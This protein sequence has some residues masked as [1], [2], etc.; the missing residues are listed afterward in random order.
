MTSKIL[1]FLIILSTFVVADIKSIQETYNQGETAQLEI[2]IPELFEEIKT[3]N[4][5]LTLNNTKQQIPFFFQKITKT[6]YFVYFDT[7]NLNPGNYLFLIKDVKT[8]GTSFLKI[9]TFNTSLEIKPKTDT[10]LKINPGVVLYPGPINYLEIKNPTDQRST[11]QITTN[12][13]AIKLHDPSFT[14]QKQDTKRITFSIDPNKIT[15][16]ESSIKINNYIIPIYFLTFKQEPDLDLYLKDKDQLTLLTSL[17]LEISD[18]TSKKG[19]LIL[20]NKINSSINNIKLSL[21]NE[22]PE[23]IELNQTSFSQINQQ[24]NSHFE[25]LINRDLT[26]SHTSYKGNLV[27]QFNNKEKIIPIQISVIF[28]EINGEPTEQINKPTSEI[29]SDSEE[30]LDLLEDEELLEEEIQGEDLPASPAS[31][32][33][34]ILIILVLIGYFTSSKTKTKKEEFNDYIKK[35]K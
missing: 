30:N 31:I 33:I 4:L 34:V 7:T 28:N 2:V 10:I 24:S 11:I 23:I 27:I 14:L 20:N 13:P 15:N 22:L 6:K 18:Q 8:L 1:F 35:I 26:A 12:E 3:S 21:T 9:K 17:N 16:Q 19:I 32:I 29:T 25:L 5:E